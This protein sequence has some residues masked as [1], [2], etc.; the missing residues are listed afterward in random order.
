METS[1][2]TEPEVVCICVGQPQVIEAAGRQVLTGIYK[3]QVEGPVAV[4][5]LNLEGDRQ[6]D[7]TVHGGA[8]KAVYCYSS[9]HY[10]A[11]QAELSRPL[12]YGA[13]GENLTVS[14]LLE[15]QVLL[16]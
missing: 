15:D 10:P 16:D 3:K 9:E 6:A 4:R 7:L 5:Y 13:F 12:D 2:R 14:G 8:D 1:Q 11:W